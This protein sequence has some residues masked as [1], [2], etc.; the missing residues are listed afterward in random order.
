VTRDVYLIVLA[1]DQPSPLAPESDEEKSEEKGGKTI[2]T[3]REGDKAKSQDVAKGEAAT[4]VRIDLDG[5]SQRIVSLPAPAENYQQLVAG[6]GGVVFLIQGPLVPRTDGSQ[7]TSVH[8]FDLEKRKAEKFLDGV[9]GSITLSNNGE[10]LLYQQSGKWFLVPTAAPPKPGEGALN[11]EGMEVRVDPPAEWRQMFREVWRIERDFLYDPGAQGLD[12]KATER[13]YSAYLDQL[14]SREDLSHVFTDMLGELSLGHVFVF[15]PRNPPGAGVLPRTGL[16]GADYRVENGRYRFTRVYHGEN[17]NPD[18]RA[19]LTQPGARVQADEYLLTVNGQDVRPPENLYCFFEGTA[20]KS[21]VLT[22]GPN[23]DSKGARE[24]TVVPVNEESALRNRAWI[25]DNRRKVA[26]LTGGRVAYVWLPD[27]F[28]GGL[29]AFNRYFFAQVDKEAAIIDERFNNGGQLA[30]YIV[31]YLR[32][33][34][35]NYLSTRDGEVQAFPA[36]AIYGP[37]VMI[38]NQLAASGGDALAYYFRQLKI[39]KLIGKRTWGSLMGI[40]GYPGLMD[41]SYVTAPHLATWFPSGQWEVENH[42]V[43]PDIDVEMDPEAWRSGRDPQLEKAVA[44]VLQ[45]LKNQPPMKPK[46]PPFPN[47][48]PKKE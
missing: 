37:K 21:V 3:K 15:D 41:G 35:L 31:D 6:T 47:Y 32:R 30:D 5:L 28:Q 16:L 44:V 22:V 38:I 11:L 20:G 2:A 9:S 43:D 7:G 12:L 4:E 10:K 48:H 45:E 46:R 40:D 14:A 24:V 27:T 33:P 1:D 39:G 19:P 34:L 17:W 29:T 13:K 8:K 26:R 23:A 36:T 42:G 18:L 25:E